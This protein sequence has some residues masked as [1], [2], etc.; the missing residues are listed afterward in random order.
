[1][2]LGHY[3][4]V[5]NGTLAKGHIC[6]CKLEISLVDCWPLSEMCTEL[7]DRNAQNTRT[8][9]RSTSTC[10]RSSFKTL[11]GLSYRKRPHRKLHC[12]EVHRCNLN[13]L[14]IMSVI[15]FEA[16]GTPKPYNDLRWPSWQ[17]P[18]L[19][20]LALLQ[21]QFKPCLC[22]GHAKGKPDKS[23]KQPGIC[24][25]QHFLGAF[26]SSL[27]SGRVS[28]VGT[29]TKEACKMPVCRLRISHRM[30]LHKLD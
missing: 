22:K 16:S 14:G 18:F 19:L 23:P 17:V 27:S 11:C 8:A 15:C 6:L 26:S 3:Q 9:S 5:G 13:V 4:L 12:K 7:K 30:H 2:A 1:M 29:M 24:K 28:L 20:E 25:N 21:T 10:A